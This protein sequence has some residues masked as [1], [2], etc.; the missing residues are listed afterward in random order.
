[1]YSDEESFPEVD[2]DNPNEQ[3]SEEKEIGEDWEASDDE[4]ESLEKGDR[5]SDFVTKDNKLSL[6]VCSGDEKDI[7]K[8]K[9]FHDKQGEKDDGSLKVID[10]KDVEDNLHEQESEDEY[11]SENESLERE[12]SL[13]SSCEVCGQTF[14]SNFSLKRH[15]YK[16][17]YSCDMCTYEFCSK[18]SLSIHAKD[19]H[20]QKKFTCSECGKEFNTKQNLKR[21]FESMSMII[22][23]M[24]TAKFCNNHDLKRPCLLRAQMQ[25]M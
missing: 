11:C 7:E 15:K 2:N 22:C 17:K 9:V 16:K 25:E 21:H 1:M 3:E 10:E 19:I 6:K 4:Q 8:S 24:C 23:G 5:S 18:G 14:A 12:V 13:N 20:S